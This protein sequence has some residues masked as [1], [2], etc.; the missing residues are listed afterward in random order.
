MRMACPNV[1]T[2]AISP[3]SRELSASAVSVDVVFMAG[4]G[5]GQ[6]LDARSAPRAPRSRPRRHE[7]DRVRSAEG[8]I[9]PDDSFGGAVGWAGSFPAF[10]AANPAEIRARLDAFVENA[11]DKQG[12]AWDASIP[13]LQDEVGEVLA[14]DSRASDYSAI[15]EYGLVLDARRA[16]VV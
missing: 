5:G 7:A 15:L 13:V 16:D 3:R 12:R 11:G 10:R 1:S 2:A 6:A 14:A 8:G 9:V 4:S